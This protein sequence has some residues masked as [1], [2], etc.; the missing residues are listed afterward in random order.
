M[1]FIH[2][3]KSANL[4]MQARQVPL[5]VGE[6]GIGKTALA[7]ELAK[8]NGWSLI[9]IEGNLLKE[10]EIGGLPTVE[11]VERCLPTG[12]TKIDKVTIYA[13]HHKLRQ[14]DEEVGKGQD[15]LL[16]IDE[17]NRSEHAVQQE[18]MNLILNR[19]INGY[20]LPPQVHV[21]A[22]MNP[23]DIYDYQTVEMD[24]AQENRFV[25]LYMEADYMQWLDWAVEHDLHPVVTEFISTY[26]DYLNAH[27]EEDINA[28][29]RSYERI[30][31]LYRLYEAMDTEGDSISEAVFF[32]VVR[33]N[34]GKIIAEEF[35]RFAASNPKPLVSYEELFAG[36]EL[37]PQI[38][39][40]IRQDSHTRLYL[41]AKN[42][43]KQLE[44]R[45]LLEMKEIPEPMMK[46]LL[47]FLKLY[48]VDLMIGLMKDLRNQYPTI[49]GK[50]IENKEFVDMYFSAYR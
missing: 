4:V 1:N 42:I 35:V 45:A 20:E 39:E 18:L 6:T 48:P 41:G 17:I 5:L 8:E 40:R 19:E 3:K 31:D 15:V 21:L 27:N 7:T 29:P 24:V 47:D 16:F 38:K 33:G 28:T 44:Q 46:R 10:G 9:T 37:N 32:N 50:A 43:F 25:W 30:S 14:V 2:T 22:A 23:T 12:E 11:T 34:V 13:T 26:P 49:Y 36:E